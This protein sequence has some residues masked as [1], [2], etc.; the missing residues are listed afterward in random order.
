MHFP[1]LRG[2]HGV[3]LHQVLGEL[4]PARWA[5]LL[6]MVDVLLEALEAEVV[7]ASGRHW[8]FAQL[9]AYAALHVLQVFLTLLNRNY[10]MIH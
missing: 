10:R 4:C 1:Q 9:Q 6:T 7:P 3:C 8:T 5:V 2:E